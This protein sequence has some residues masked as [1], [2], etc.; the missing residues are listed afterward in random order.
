VTPAHRVAL[1][2]KTG[3]GSTSL[4]CRTPSPCTEHNWC[5][6][7]ISRRR[8]FRSTW[9]TMDSW[10]AIAQM[11]TG[12]RRAR[13]QRSA[14]ALAGASRSPSCPDP[15]AQMYR[16]RRKPASDRPARQPSQSRQRENRALS[17]ATSR[18]GPQLKSGERNTG[19]KPRQ[20]GRIT[21][22]AARSVVLALHQTLPARTH[23]SA[24]IPRGGG[25]ACA[26]GRRRPASPTARDARWICRIYLR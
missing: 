8:P 14:R 1:P 18:A 12:F 11:P 20:D 19:G 7:T 26:D 5:S 10:S 15:V 24:P 9:S 21:T 13:R 4:Q 25:P 23:L 22:L 16:A 3:F 17:H 2:G 6:S